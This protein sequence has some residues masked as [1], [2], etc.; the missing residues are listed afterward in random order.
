MKHFTAMVVILSLA[1]CKKDEISTPAELTVEPA[2]LDFGTIGLGSE[3]TQEITVTNIGGGT[4]GILSLTLTEGD[5]DV[6]SVDRDGINEVLAGETATMFVTF[7][8]EETQRES[9][10]AQLRTDVSGQESFLINLLG[11]G[12]P[13]TAD[14]DGDGVSV[15]DGDCDDGNAD[16]YPGAPEL[17][18]GVD[19]DCNDQVPSDEDDNDGDGWRVCEDDCDDDNNARNPGE[20]EICDGIDNDCDGINADYDDNDGDGL[21]IC[22]GDCDDTEGQVSPDLA[23]ICDDGLDNDCDGEIDNIDEDEDG[24]SLCGDAPDCD[25]ADAG[26][27][28]IVVATDGSSDGD[29]TEADP[30]DE[31]ADAI[32]NL[33]GVCNTVYIQPGTYEFPLLTWTS[34][35]LHIEGL[36]AP[37]DVVLQAT[38]DSRHANITGGDVTFRDLTLTEGSAT[39]DGGSISV[40]NAD[41]TLSN[42]T[43]LNNSSGNDGGAVS[44]SSGT[45][46]L[47]RSPIFEGNVAQDDGGAILLDAST[48]DDTSGTEYIGNS[49][50]KGG[51]IYMVGGSAEITDAIFRSNVGTNEGGAIAATGTPGS[52][53]VERNQFLLNDAVVDGGAL[54]LRDF[55]APAGTFRNNRVQDNTSG[56]RGGGL[57]IVGAE[58]AIQVHNNTFTGNTAVDDGGAVA[59]A[60]TNNGDGIQVVS[61]VMHSNDGLSALYMTPGLGSQIQYN[62]GFGTNSGLHF[63]GGLDDGGGTPVDPTNLDDVN[64]SL[65]AYS[66]DGNPDNDDLALGGGSPAIDAGP[67]VAL[68]DDLDGSRNDLGY[69]GGP[70]AAE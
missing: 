46:T 63:G 12:G 58:G 10:Q 21:S 49:G 20:V 45:L 22:D 64:P 51:A 66:A 5:S 60:V 47:R 8:P 33:D 13:S 11:V 19:D 27:Y 39:E 70:A 4:A 28:P 18:N 67:D 36:G 56:A 25:D 37:S 38:K 16:R 30:Y 41:L 57:A 62:I 9:G 44:V 48:L 40:S 59:V 3:T 35:D 42:A 65:V 31:I 32:A 54:A 50:Q 55:D 14:Y 68:F 1:A 52:F 29:G 61:T 69:T 43:L 15:A 26:S 6:W 34:G 23:E 7:R 24:H 53:V 17:C 2:S